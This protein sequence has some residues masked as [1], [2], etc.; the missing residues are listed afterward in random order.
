[1]ALSV[2]PSSLLISGYSAYLRSYS[3]A[4]P[5]GARAPDNSSSRPVSRHARTSVLAVIRAKKDDLPEIVPGPH[6]DPGRGMTAGTDRQNCLSREPR[7]VR[8]SVAVC[9]L[10]SMLLGMPASTGRMLGLPVSAGRKHVYVN[11]RGRMAVSL[12]SF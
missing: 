8:P 10:R 1:M 9:M 12:S 4:W 2:A 3:S 6:E 5:T 11:I 7:G